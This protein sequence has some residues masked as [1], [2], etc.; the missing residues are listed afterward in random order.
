[1]NVTAIKSRLDE[2]KNG[3][4]CYMYQVDDMFRIALQLMQ[5]EEG[6]RIIANN[7]GDDE[8]TIE[9]AIKSFAEIA[10]MAF[11]SDSAETATN[12]ANIYYKK[13]ISGKV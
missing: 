1:M 4:F 13:Y 3:Q 5:S 10:Y 6:K 11:L 8:R 12:D 7:F 9:S 2:L